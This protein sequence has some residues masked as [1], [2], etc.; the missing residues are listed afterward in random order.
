M[1][2]SR[3]AEI[4]TTL[5]GSM[6]RRRMAPFSRARRVLAPLSVVSTMASTGSPDMASVR[7]LPRTSA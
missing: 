1:G 2:T 5:H 3:C 4:S 6:H 7:V